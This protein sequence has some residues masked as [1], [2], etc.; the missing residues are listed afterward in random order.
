MKILTIITISFL[1]V[2]SVSNSYGELCKNW[3]QAKTAG[4]LDHKIIAEASGIAVSKLNKN[5]LYHVNDSGNGSY[6]YSTYM[7]GSNTK[8]ILIRDFDSSKADFEDM[9]IGPCYSKTCLFIGDIGDNNKARDFI[10]ILVIEEKE[11]Y[12]SHVKPIKIVK[13][14]YPDHPHDA[15]AL[16]V[17]PNGDL[18]IITKEANYKRN[19]SFPSKL[20]KIEREKWE[21]STTNVLMLDLIGTINI[22]SINETQTGFFD[23]IITSFDIASN[24]KKFV[25]LTYQ[26]AYEFNIDLSKSNTNNFNNLT[27]DTDFKIVEIKRLPQQESTTYLHDSR[28]LL[29][30]SEYIGVKSKLIRIDC[31]D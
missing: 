9:T 11:N 23:N 10:K 6:F 15:E 29:Y 21:N 7:D 12:K 31:L 27:K 3:G 1:Y 16:A 26:N 14:A 18:Y 13:L 19:K 30:D 17:H 2:L 24:G 4:A 20:F 8:S 22:E 5:R 25:A 28:S